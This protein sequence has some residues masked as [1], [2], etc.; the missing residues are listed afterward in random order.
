MNTAIELRHRGL[1]VAY[2]FAGSTG[3]WMAHLFFASGFV[4]YSCNAHGTLWYQYVGT[5]VCAL[6]VLHAMWI[7]YGLY[8][9]GRTDSEDAGTRLGA[10]TFIGAVGIIVCSANLLLI[11]GEGSFAALIHQGCHL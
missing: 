1:R 6:V 8:R 4:Q 2:V 10:N 3:A 7:A 11:L 5:A 9:E